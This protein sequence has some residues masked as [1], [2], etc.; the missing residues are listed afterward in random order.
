METDKYVNSYIPRWSVRGKCHNNADPDWFYEEDD[1]EFITKIKKDYCE[2]C[3][4]KTHCLFTA[5]NEDEKWGIWGGLT[6]IERGAY[7]RRREDKMTH[8]E[9]LDF[10]KIKWAEKVERKTKKEAKK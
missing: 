5:I 6:P 1:L 3:P 10:L 8:E 4:V 7:L 2:E 9:V